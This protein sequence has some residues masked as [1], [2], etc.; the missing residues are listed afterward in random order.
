MIGETRRSR[1][2]LHGRNLFGAQGSRRARAANRRRTQTRARRRFLPGARLTRLPSVR[3]T[4]RASGRRGGNSYALHDLGARYHAIGKAAARGVRQFS[5]RPS[6]RPRPM[7]R[8]PAPDR[9]RCDARL[10]DHRLLPAKS[11]SC[12]TYGIPTIAPGRRPTTPKV[13]CRSVHREDA[14]LSKPSARPNSA[15]SEVVGG[16]TLGTSLFPLTLLTGRSPHLFLSL[17]AGVT[18]APAR[19]F[20]V[21]PSEA[22]G[23]RIFTSAASKI[24]GEVTLGTSLFPL[25]LLTGTKSRIFS[26]L[27]VQGSPP[28]LNTGCRGHPALPNIATLPIKSPDCP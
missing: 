4:D 14:D 16:V 5:A 12:P 8:D 3:W 10:R 18:S 23:P 27:W 20:C 13:G 6:D 28:A 24:T 22:E 11:S 2:Q 21:I 17:V 19:L 26:Y 1:V 9:P 25:T 7:I 15:A